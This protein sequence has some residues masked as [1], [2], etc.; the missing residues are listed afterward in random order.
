MLKRGQ[1]TLI[2][3]LPAALFAACTITTSEDD[4]AGGATGSGGDAATTTGNG[5]ST[6][7]GG[8]GGE[9]TGGGATGGGGAVDC[10]TGDIG[11]P[12]GQLCNDC[13][14]CAGN[15]A[16]ADEQAACDADPGCT[17]YAG[18]VANC[19]MSCTSL[20]PNDQAC[21]DGCFPSCVNGVGSCTT[22]NVPGSEAYAT[23]LKCAVC[24]ACSH[25]CNA[26][27]WTW[28]FECGN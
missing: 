24:S 22:D 7:Q 4:G 6:S 18:C 8:A 27:T 28:F 12:G 10:D 23:L 21:F 1:F 17:S 5:G 26:P 19:E 15:N 11:G 25:N 20:C 2:M 9:G 14:A 16:C 3:A 13:I